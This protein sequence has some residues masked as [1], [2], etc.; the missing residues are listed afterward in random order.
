[1]ITKN[2][3]TKNQEKKGHKTCLSYPFFRYLNHFVFFLRDNYF[4]CT[5]ND[6]HSISHALL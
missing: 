1:M 3:K 6:V 2:E 4:L 5:G